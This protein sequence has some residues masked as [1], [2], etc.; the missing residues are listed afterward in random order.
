MPFTDATGAHINTHMINLVSMFSPDQLPYTTIA[1]YSDI[2]VYYDA[3][4]PKQAIIGFAAG[5]CQAVQSVNKN[6]IQLYCQEKYKS[7]AQ[8]P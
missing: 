2:G 5:K 6:F 1:V 7:R 3:S 4:L 8:I